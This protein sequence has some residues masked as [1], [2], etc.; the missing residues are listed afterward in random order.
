MAFIHAV[1]AIVNVPF[2]TAYFT[3]SVPRQIGDQGRRAKRIAEI[4]SHLGR[5]YHLGTILPRNEPENRR[6]ISRYVVQSNA[7]V[8]TPRSCPNRF[9]SHG[10][11]K[12][13]GGIV[14]GRSGRGTS[15]AFCDHGKRGMPRSRRTEVDGKVSA[16]ANHRRA[17][18]Q[19][20]SAADQERSAAKLPRHAEAASGPIL[21][22]RHSI[23]R[24]PLQREL[25]QC[26]Q[27]AAFKAVEIV[28]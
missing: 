6:D 15:A 8:F 28:H 25:R 4:S 17:L 16:A 10:W 23:T 2:V 22:H 7:A 5:Y 9:L 12:W 3:K 27:I 19:K 13:K 14:E 24:T 1:L 18:R 20:S 11:E 26:N 21:Y